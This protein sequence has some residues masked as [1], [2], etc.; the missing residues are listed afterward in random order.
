[1]IPGLNDFLDY[2]YNLRWY[3]LIIVA[4]F[5]ICLAVG[6]SIGMTMPSLTDNTISDLKDQVG[7]LKETSAVGPMLGIFGN[8]VIKCFAVTIGGLLVGLAP[9]AFTVANGIVVGIACGYTMGKSG[10]MFVLVGMLPHGVIEI[11]MVFLS[12]AIGLKL[13]A[14][15]LRLAYRFITAVIGSFRGSEVQWSFFLRRLD[16][17]WKDFR[18]GVLIFVFWVA[19]LLFVAA[20]LETFVTGTLLYVLFAH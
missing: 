11:P 6:Y 4:I 3:L 7:P 5:A 9:L 19:P 15:T 16:G 18:E 8:N 20:F 10:L 17:I 12:A 14:D 1:M 2:A 13:G